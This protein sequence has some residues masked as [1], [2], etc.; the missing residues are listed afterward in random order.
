VRRVK[1]K[2]RKT[3]TKR[4]VW[5]CLANGLAWVWCSY[6]LAALGREAIAEELSRAAVTE[7]VAVVLVYCLKALLEKKE[8]FGNVGKDEEHE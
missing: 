3:T 1:R 4:I 7:L 8:E 6:L 5:L 2:K